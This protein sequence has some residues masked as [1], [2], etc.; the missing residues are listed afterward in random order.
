MKKQRKME[1][2]STLERA[3]CNHDIDILC[4][5]GSKKI[6]TFIRYNLLNTKQ[7]LNSRI[8]QAL[9]LVPPSWTSKG[10]ERRNENEKAR[11]Q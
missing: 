3:D 1:T 11:Q 9:I 2:N 5:F 8:A 7:H 10:T 4:L 6:T